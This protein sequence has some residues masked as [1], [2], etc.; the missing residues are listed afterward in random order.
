[1][2]AMDRQPALTHY[3]TTGQMAQLNGVS[4]KTLRLYQKRGLLI[5]A[6]VDEASGYRY[7][8]LAQCAQLDVIQQFQAIGFSLQQIEEI[9]QKEDVHGLS[10]LMRRQVSVL[11]QEIERLTLARAAARRIQESCD[12]VLNKPPCEQITVEWMPARRF[13]YFDIKHYDY[14]DFIDVQREGFVNWEMTLR[15]VKRQMTQLGLPLSLFQNV[16]CITDNAC[17]RRGDFVITGA[18]IQVDRSFAFAGCTYYELPAG[19]YI[20]CYCEG[21]EN[22]MLSFTR[23]AALVHR[24]LDEIKTRGY[25]LTGDYLGDVMADTPVF[26]YAARESFLRLQIGIS[27]AER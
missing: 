5:P 17:L 15:M 16:C 2:D 26:H 3:L 27:N 24:L 22:G 8:T 1:M 23:E 11:D 25:A 13:L 19:L 7:Y 14:S 21:D 10:M 18:A 20:S 9:L 12:V 4:K 6:Y